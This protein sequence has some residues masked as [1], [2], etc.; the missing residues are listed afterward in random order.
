MKFLMLPLFFAVSCSTCL[1][2]DDH[3][4]QWRGPLATGEAP[5]ANPPTEWSPTKNIKWKAKLPGR[6]HSTPIVWKDHIFLTS[7]IPFGKKLKPRYSGA[8]GAHDN[9]PI[10]RRHRFVVICLNRK[11]GKIRWQ[12]TMHEALP[13]EGGHHTA[14]LASASP[15]TDGKLVFAFFGSYGLYCLD[16]EGNL[17]WKKQ[18]GKLNTKHGHGEGSSP[19]LHDG[20]LIVN[21]DHEGQSFIVALEKTTGKQIWR[22]KRDEV[23]SWST[24][25][26]VS[27]GKK[28]YAI[29]PGTKRIRAY[30][31]KSGTIQW[32]CGGLSANIVASPVA[33]HGMVFLGSSYERRAFLAIRLAGAKG[34]I[35]NK[36]NVVW[37]RGG[38]TPYVPS[39]L[40]Y[41]GSLYFLRHYQGVLVRADAKTG[42]DQGGPFRLVG[43]RNVYASPVAAAGRV[44]LTDRDGV[45]L[46][47][48][49]GGKTPKILAVNRLGD[50]VNASAA[51]VGNEMYLRGDQLLYCI[52]KEKPE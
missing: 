16:F 5:N 13:H 4:P 21:Q 23:T 46:V 10:T 40:L 19:V 35:T 6:G 8:P 30:D 2:A 34:D 42:E 7:A 45:T 48:S 37:K 49:H 25:I 18:T 17:K 22:K 15:V 29:V 33:G 52:A 38:A 41:K 9:L 26:V 43:I 3:W 24:P 51:V 20:T 28:D 11:D 32:E 14:S 36:R 50:N 27:E 31:L 39:P 1:G 47:L 12:K 44:Y